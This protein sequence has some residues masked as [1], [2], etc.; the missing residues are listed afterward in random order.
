MPNLKYLAIGLVLL[1]VL[2][3]QA[4]AQTQPAAIVYLPS[5]DGP[6]LVE[7][8]VGACAG[9]AAIG[10]LVVLATGVGAPLGTA[11]L[12]CGLSV[13]ASVASTTASWGWRRAADYLAR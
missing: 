5:D 4:R 13:A 1:S 6:Q 12:F 7:T 11:G 3:P 10:Y 8:A 2:A 9:G